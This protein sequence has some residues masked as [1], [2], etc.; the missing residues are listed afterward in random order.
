MFVNHLVELHLLLLVVIAKIMLIAHQ[1]FALLVFANLVVVAFLAFQMVALALLIL[2]AHH[3]S[4]Q[5]QT[6]ASQLALIHKEQVHTVMVVRV[7]EIVTV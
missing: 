3:S 6:H 4:V 2:N 7:K 5:L 1:V